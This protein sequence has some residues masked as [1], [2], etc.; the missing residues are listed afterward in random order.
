[1]VRGDSIGGATQA[2]GNAVLSKQHLQRRTGTLG[3]G[4]RK[5]VVE[6]QIVQDIPSL[7]PLTVRVRDNGVVVQVLP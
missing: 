6:A 1:M 2:D 5:Y 4:W 3:I 7:Q